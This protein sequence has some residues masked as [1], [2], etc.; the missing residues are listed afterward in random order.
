VLTA[1]PLPADPAVPPGPEA[2]RP[3]GRAGAPAPGLAPPDGRARP[4]PRS[5]GG[6]PTAGPRPAGTPGTSRWLTRSCGRSGIRIWVT[7][8]RR[9][10]SVST[11]DERV[12]PDV[13]QRLSV[14]AAGDR[15]EVLDEVC[16]Q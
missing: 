6:G 7:S 16:R 8:V 12:V 3:A 15:E 4:G 9:R 10:P 13:G 2:R 5:G 14:P 1:S 11:R